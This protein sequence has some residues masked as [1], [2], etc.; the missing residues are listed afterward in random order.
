[1]PILDEFQGKLLNRLQDDRLPDL[2]VNEGDL[3]RRFVLPLVADLQRDFPSLHIYAHPWKQR[4][5]CVPDCTH[6]LGLIGGPEPH[7]CPDCWEA[8]KTWAAVRFFG[9]HCFD[10]VVGDQH[11]SLAL[12]LKLLQRPRTGKRKAND[13]FQRLIGQCTLARLA[14][15]RVVGFCVAEDGALGE[16]G[17]GKHLS[18]LADRGIRIV[19]R[20]CQ[21]GIRPTSGDA[22]DT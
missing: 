9:L 12:E 3:E 20:A 7:G 17:T 10:L 14:H 19:V 16:S 11:D 2:L 15:P 18:A 5:K 21:P 6:G 8:S 4:A 13:G 1:M 22:R